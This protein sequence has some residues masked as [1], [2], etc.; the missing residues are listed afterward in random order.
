MKKR[1]A[2]GEGSIYPYKDGFAASIEL[3]MAESARTPGKMT[4]QRKTVYGKTKKEVAEKL[5]AV[6]REVE[7]GGRRAIVDRQTVG[8]FLETWLRDVVA[9]NNRPKT[10]NSYGQLVRLYIAPVIGGIQL[11]KLSPQDVQRM[12]NRTR[13]AGLSPRT[14][15]YVRGVLR[16][17]L[18]QAQRWELV[19][20]NAAALTEPPKVERYITHPLTTEQAQ[21]LLDAAR[22][23]RLEALYYI[24]LSLGLREGEV[25]GLR[26]QDISL[27]K[28]TL[29]VRKKLLRLN[30]QFVLES[31]KTARS[32][33]TLPLP[34]ALLPALRSHRARQAEERLALG[35]SWQDEWGLVFTTE[36]GLPVHPR[37]LFR[38]FQ[39]LLKRAGLPEIRFHDLRHS[40]ASILAAQGVPA[41]VAMEILGHASITTTQNVYTHV[42]DD[43]KR[44][45]VD[46]MDR[47][48]GEQGTD[49]EDDEKDAV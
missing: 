8:D 43:S 23:D 40:C 44:G 29:S 17:A 35:P 31:P 42:L 10:H 30:G 20:K 47:L 45:A 26:W 48:F 6:R 33:R 18:T 25:L 1:R 32:V 12:L 22:G 14:V 38:A 5:N 19:T 3:G 2:S 4:R 41:R 21:H 7:R 36:T 16:A 27:E 39:R 13:D 37:N 49:R 11:T 34:A 15:Q 46:V 9:T 24:A 28:R